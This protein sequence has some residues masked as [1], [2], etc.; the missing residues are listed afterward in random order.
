MGNK[1]LRVFGVVEL[2]PTMKLRLQLIQL[3]VLEAE[4]NPS[5]PH[6]RHAS[7]LKTQLQVC[8]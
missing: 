7:V 1:V 5:H 6:V 8:L 4:G 2:L 3:S